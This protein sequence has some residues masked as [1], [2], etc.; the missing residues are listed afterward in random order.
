MNTA[1]KEKETKGKYELPSLSD[2]E[3]EKLFTLFKINTEDYTESGLEKILAKKLKGRPA[4]EVIAEYEKKLYAVP[5]E[6]MQLSQEEAFE[7]YIRAGKGRVGKNVS[8][9]TD[10]K[11]MLKKLYNRLSAMDLSIEEARELP[12]VQPKTG[13]RRGR[14]NKVTNELSVEGIAFYEG[15]E[16]DN[17][18]KLTQVLVD[19]YED[20]KIGY[21]EGK[22]YDM[23][24]FLSVGGDFRFH[25]PV[26]KNFIK[27]FGAASEDA[28]A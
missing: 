14:A 11:A 2:E 20:L 7:L 3:R 26:G 8:T 5:D 4:N 10:R 13:G 6:F 24:V 19:N 22:T 18:V 28:I 23:L 9:E 21:Y 1:T 15:K 27:V 16:F 17:V 25:M 12:E